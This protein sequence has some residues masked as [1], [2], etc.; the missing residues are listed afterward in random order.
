MFHPGI[1]TGSPERGHKTGGVGETSHF[2][3]F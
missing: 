2:G 1:L 3:I